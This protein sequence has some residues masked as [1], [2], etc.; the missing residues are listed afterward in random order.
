MGQYMAIQ[1]TPDAN[2]LF[3]LLL[4]RYVVQILS[5]LVYYFICT[6]SV[7]LSM[8]YDVKLFNNGI[9]EQTA[10]CRHLYNIIY[11]YILVIN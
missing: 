9:M 6:S 4:T 10:E 1:Y 8:F 7:V 3:K 2:W 5:Q 11:I